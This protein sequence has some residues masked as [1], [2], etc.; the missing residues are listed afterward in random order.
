MSEQEDEVLRLAKRENAKRV[1]RESGIAEMLQGINKNLLKGR[2]RFEE[3]DSMVLFKWGT[4]STL[5]HMWIEVVDD[6]MRFRFHQHRKCA[7]PV[8]ICDGEYHTFTSA[9][10]KN[11]A[12]M[13]AELKKYYDR[14]V[15]ESSSD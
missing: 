2:G 9:M 13:Q 3:Y 14:P 10:W 8:P 11:R 4:S 5:R 7:N 12:F 15:A 6:T 1:F